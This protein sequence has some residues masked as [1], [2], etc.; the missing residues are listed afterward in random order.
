MKKLIYSALALAAGLFATSC[1]QENLETVQGG[2]TVTFTVSVPEVATKAVGDGMNVNKLVYAV[3]RAADADLADPTKTTDDALKGYLA[4]PAY[5]NKF[6][7]VYQEDQGLGV[8]TTNTIADKSTVV[9]LELINDQRYIVLFW[10]QQDFTW[11]KKDDQG[12]WI[13]FKTVEYPSDY[14]PNDDK[15]AA[16]SGVS[17]VSVDGSVSKNI[18]LTR[19]FAQVNIAAAKPAEN[20]YPNLAVKLSTVKIKGIASSFNVA[21]QKGFSETPCDDHSYTANG[22]VAETY[23]VSEYPLYISM[24]YIFV[25]GNDR[26]NV[27]VEYDITSTYGNG[28]TDETTVSNTIANVPVAKNYKTNIVG[29]LLTSGVEYNVT[30]ENWGDTGKDIVV[31]NDGVVMNINGDYEVTNNNGLI[32]AINN[33]WVDKDGDASP[34]TFYVYPGEYTIT[35]DQIKDIVVESGTLKVIRAIPILTRSTVFQGIVIKGL[36]KPLIKKV[37]DGATVVLSGITIEDYEGDTQEAG[38]LIGDN[39]GTVIIEECDFVTENDEVSDEIKDLIGGNGTVEEKSGNEVEENS[40]VVYDATQLA[41]AFANTEVKSIVLGGNITVEETLVFPEGRTA[42]LDLKGFELTI[43]GE[44]NVATTYVLNNQGD[45]TIKDSY[46]IGKVNARGIYNGYGNGGENVSA[47]KL[48]IES[49]NFNAMGTNGGAAV[50]NYGQVE[51]KGGKF[52][53]D[54]GYGLNNQAGA[55]MT[56]DSAN[57]RGGV[58]NCGTL[59]INSSEVYQHLSGKHAIYNW[60]GSVTICGGKFDSES[61]NELILADGQNAFV[62]ITGGEFHKTA[63]S[64]LFGAATGK[65]ITFEITGGTYYG[66]VN[67]PEMTVDT[68]RPYGDPIVVKGGSYNFDANNWCHKDYKAVKNEETAMWDVVEKVYVAKIGEDGY[69]TLQEAFNKAKSEETITLLKN[70]IL[71]ETAVFPEGKVAILDLNGKNITVA[72]SESNHIYAINNKGVLTLKDSQG[73]GSVT[74]RGIY[75]GY[76]G[77]STET[78]AG[79]KM[80][81]ESGK[82]IAMDSN[83]GAAILNCAELVINGG[84]F[85]GI[86]ASVNNRA[87]GVAELNGGT[88]SG[89]GSGSYQLQNNG[90]TLTINNATVTAGF[91]AVGN[92]SGVTVIN[93]GTFNPTGRKASTCHVVYVAAAATVTI[94]GGTFKMNYP[95]DAVPDS[96]SAVSSYYNGTLE[97]NGGTFYSHFDNV[98]PVELSSGSSIKGGTYYTHS[99][100]ASDHQY[101]KKYVAEAYELVDGK[102]QLKPVAKVGNNNYT[103]I[104]DAIAAW[105]NNTTLTLLADVTL[106]DVVTLKSTEHHILNLQTYTMTAA[107]G[108]DAIE[109][110]CNGLSNATYALT[111][112]ADATNPGGITATSKSCIYYKKSDSTKDRPIILIN[113]GV[114]TGSYSINS[115]SNGN[116][117]CPQV[118]IN[119]G[120]FNSYMNLTKNML[121]VSGGTFHAAINCTGDSSA[122]RE[123]K[124]GRFKSWQFMTADASNK[125]WVGSGNGNYNVGVYVDKE[126]YLV[127]GGPVITEGNVN[128]NWEKKQYSSWSDYLKYSS[129]ATYGLYYEK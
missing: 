70:I 125:F 47:A 25:E 26:G 14:N 107:S 8:G 67:Q 119:G 77:D 117:N 48:T 115:T 46:G 5:E 36:S 34:A 98:S 79:A 69:E 80:I 35:D 72:D 59:A 50:Y 20:R 61:G 102:V 24:N 51:I 54:G 122:Y 91:G 37:E 43:A 92:Y 40:T 44:E 88:F 60:A 86:V 3:Y 81:V 41:A 109:I 12:N 76:N 96:G 23:S 1:L 17:V 28:A 18:V 16:F 89:P 113:N 101:I 19:P 15:Y 49:G 78:V 127:V 93:D 7:L 83:G 9:S 124:G 75:N 85:E 121:K 6:R 108:K 111:V 30:L 118:W 58:Y 82:Y 62:Q 104:D 65:N 11:V 73:N 112:N 128:P 63:K 99:G 105:T 123:I 39:A 21:T 106:N 66:Y 97:I 68:F 55:V 74:A 10:A 53:S 87:K 31:V 103:T 38:A 126:G 4:D 64:W 45:L 2:S 33:L 42:T 57:V 22:P 71:A 95:E 32:Y 13:E 90:G 120:V 84:E 110:T 29:N 52:S 56:V 129:A 27:E 114:F 116:T 100:L 94:N